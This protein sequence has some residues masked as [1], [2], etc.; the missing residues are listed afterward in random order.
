M[1]I[2]EEKLSNIPSIS[3]L[4]SNVS[5]P[6]RPLYSQVANN[7]SM[8]VI[9]PKNE[10]QSNGQTK[11]DIMRTL[12]PVDLDISVSKVKNIQSGGILIGC[13]KPDDVHKFKQMAEQKLSAGYK[14]HEVKSN[15]PKLKLV[16]MIEKYS[17][18]QLLKFL[19][20]QNDVFS[21]DSKCS[22]VKIWS[23]KNNKHLYQALLDID[24]ITFC[25]VMT[26]GNLF[27]N[28]DVCSVFDAT[29]LKICYKCSGF[30]HFQTSCKSSKFVCPKC[31]LDHSVKE[32][33]SDAVPRCANCV[34]AKLAENKHFVWDI[35]KCTVYQKKLEHYKLSIF[36]NK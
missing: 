21:E 32:C 19:K 1:K 35:K 16:G 2:A 3:N 23:T 7:E 30:N 24:R 29:D 31:S 4:N 13:N 34:N 22:V 25:K 11:S 15:N 8:I 36:S 20:A 26:Q 18:D 9:K 6:I 10:D 27:V 17:E 14:I 5:K 28:Y 12:N 33:P